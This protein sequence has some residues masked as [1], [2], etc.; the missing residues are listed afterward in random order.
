MISPFPDSD[1]G[2]WAPRIGM[3]KMPSIVAELGECAR[4]PVL[5]SAIVE[6]PFFRLLRTGCTCALQITFH[7][8]AFFKCNHCFLEMPGVLISLRGSLHSRK[9]CKSG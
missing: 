4:T 8:G 6:R 5:T 9:F 3:R 7:C 1:C 2:P